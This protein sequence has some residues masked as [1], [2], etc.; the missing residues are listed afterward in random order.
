LLCSSLAFDV[1]E[2]NK[3]RSWLKVDTIGVV[4]LAEVTAKHPIIKQL[5][6]LT[7]FNSIPML[8][9]VVFG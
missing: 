8:A 7:D 3:L 1:L 9:K 5:L 4:E 2:G 6:K